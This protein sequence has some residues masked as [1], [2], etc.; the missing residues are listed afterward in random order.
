MDHADVY[1]LSLRVKEANIHKTTFKTRYGHY[2][3]LVMPFGLTNAPIEDEHDEHLRVVLQ[4]LR[5]KQLYAKFRKCEFWLREP[6]NVTEI[7]SFLGLTGYYRRFVE[8]LSLIA[9]PLTKLLRK[10]V[11]FNWTDAQ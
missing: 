11:P 10:G 5:E 2:E 1:R 4:T 8:G 6:R 9:A 7:H 3:F